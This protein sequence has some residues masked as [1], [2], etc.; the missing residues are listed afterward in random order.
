MNK[1]ILV[2][3]FCVLMNSCERLNLYGAGGGF[4]LRY[5]SSHSMNIDVVQRY[6]DTL[7]KTNIHFPPK[8]LSGMGNILPTEKIV[9]FNNDPVECY[10]LLVDDGYSCVNSI[11][12]GNSYDWINNPKYIKPGEEAR[13]EKRLGEYWLEIEQLAKKDGMPDSMLYFHVKW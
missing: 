7:A 1:L 2:S 5:C 4:R 6:I 9:C 13:I 10:R 11:T 3:I 8:K 12:Y